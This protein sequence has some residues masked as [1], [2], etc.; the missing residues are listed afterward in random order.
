[1]AFQKVCIFGHT[2]H[3]GSTLV[4]QIVDDD[5]IG[6]DHRNPTDIIGLANTQGH[7]LN[8]HGIHNAV[9]L[10]DRERFT[11]VARP[12]SDIETILDKVREMGLSGDVVFV[13]AT[14]DASEV[15]LN[16]HKIIRQARERLVTANKSPL[17]LCSFEDFAF[18]TSEPGLYRYNASVMAGGDAVTFVQESR[19]IRDPIYAIEGCLSGTLAY[20]TNELEKEDPK[21]FSHIVRYAYD[22]HWTEPNP[23]DDLSG[24]DVAKKLLILARSDGLH[25]RLKDIDLQPFIDPKFGTIPSVPE[26]LNAIPELDPYF[27]NEMQE[28]KNLGMTLRYMAEL[29]KREEK[30]I[31]RVGLRRVPKQSPLG[32]LEGT[33]NLVLIITRDR[34]P[35]ECPHR[36]ISKGAGL[37]KTAAAIRV[38]LGR[39]L[40][41]ARIS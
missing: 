34:A 15:M 16:T 40:E 36:I 39:L 19:L 31:L 33:A 25:V 12:Y 41:N 10:T 29:K 38:D 26:F 24:L 2:G 3:V 8:P 23:W 7:L 20:I 11:Q 30:T 1:M 32:Q 6:H 18:L 17:A 4:Q 27:A 37:I 13:D 28:S 14:N 22:Q 35:A 5:G 21:P 9:D